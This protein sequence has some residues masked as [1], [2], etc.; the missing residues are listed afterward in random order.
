MNKRTN[1]LII[2]A[3]SLLLLGI[4]IT[5]VALS[6]MNWN[7]AGLSTVKYETNNHEVTNAYSVISLK[8]TTADV[9][10]I[11]SDNEKTS[12]VCYEAKNQKHTVEVTDGILKIEA[13]DTRKWYEHIGISFDSPKVTVYIP[14]GE[15]DA[16]AI[17]SSTG[18]IKIPEGSNFKSIEANASTGDISLDGITA[19][20]IKLSVSTGRV[21]VSNVTSTEKLEITVSTG[22]TELNN[23]KTGS[24]IS[25]GNT[26]K[27]SMRDV[28]TYGRLDIER[29]T[30]DITFDRCDAAEVFI[31][32]D[33]GSV[34][35]EFLTEKIIFAKTDTGDV[36]APK[37]TSGGRC[38]INTNTG[39]IKITIAGN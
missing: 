11:P 24:L 25:S 22:K 27:L 10:F 31:E 1:A 5:V 7:F 37:L 33:T 28:I 14:K 13:T 18:D 39:D 38:E 9:I 17:N 35:G 8:T 23:I 4:A 3:S 21:S 26:G 36:E 34:R 12:V 29:S 19:D 30:G 15:Y 32:T 20:N 2:I 6:L 16:L